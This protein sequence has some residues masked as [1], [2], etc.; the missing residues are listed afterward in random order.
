MYNTIRELIDG[1]EKF[2]VFDLETTGFNPKSCDKDGEPRTP[3]VPI[4]ISA[5][6][7]CL[8]V[9]NNNIAIR[10]EEVFDRYININR[11][12]PPEIVDIT[13][14]TDEFLKEHGDDEKDVYRCWTDFLVDVSFVSGY[15]SNFDISFVDYMAQRYGGEFEPRTNLD[16]MKM[17][18]HFI[19]KSYIPNY[20]LGTVAEFYGVDAKFHNAM[21]DVRATK[22]LLE[23]FIN[24]YV[25]K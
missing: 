1:A 20:K 15:N 3:D 7:C 4:Q 16:V 12:L 8:E 21:E 14:I 13:G 2:V 11:P 5:I 19:P 9:E 25:N 17:A 6:K 10:E 22:E 24:Q 23:I 18:R